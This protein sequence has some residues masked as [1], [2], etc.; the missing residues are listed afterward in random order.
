[1]PIPEELRALV[2]LSVLVGLFGV[3]WWACIWEEEED[4]A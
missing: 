3:L 2:S 1:M 4:D